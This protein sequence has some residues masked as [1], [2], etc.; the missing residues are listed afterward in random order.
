[1]QSSGV[2]WPATESL[3]RLLWQTMHIRFNRF[4]LHSSKAR[5]TA[6]AS[7][8]TCSE[9]YF[10]GERL[11]ASAAQNAEIESPRFSIGIGQG[12]GL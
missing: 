5:K 9:V 12:I 1:M 4:H 6:P 3:P 7:G 2:C 11:C 8:S 10:A